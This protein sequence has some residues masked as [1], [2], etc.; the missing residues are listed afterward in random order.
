LETVK[1]PSTIRDIDNNAFEGCIS[2]TSINIP[3][4]VERIRYLAFAGCESLSNIIL[5]NTG[6][7][8]VFE[9]AFEDCPNLNKRWG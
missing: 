7:C 2:L 6:K 3:P 8:I 9:N 1:L 5:P 4:S